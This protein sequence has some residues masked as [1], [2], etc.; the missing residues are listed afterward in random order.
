MP[1]SDPRLLCKIAERQE[2]IL[3]FR[4]TWIGLE[5]CA[6]SKVWPESSPIHISYCP[7]QT[8]QYAVVRHTVSKP[9]TSRPQ[10]WSSIFFGRSKGRARRR[11]F[12]VLALQFWSG[13]PQTASLCGSLRSS[14]Q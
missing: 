13:N 11:S 9:S 7:H 5:R 10:T 3:L 4:E 6:D 8:L 2:L 12:A 14:R 1:L